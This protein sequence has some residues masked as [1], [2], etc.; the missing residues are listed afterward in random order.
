[1]RVVHQGRPCRWQWQ[2]PLSPSDGRFN[3]KRKASG[4]AKENNNTLNAR[5]RAKREAELREEQQR[6]LGSGLD[7]ELTDEQAKE[8]VMNQV[9]TNTMVADFMAA[10]TTDNPISGYFSITGRLI[11]EEAT[12][13][14]SNT[15][16]RPVVQPIDGASDIRAGYKGLLTEANARL[17]VEYTPEPLYSSY[18]ILNINKIEY[19]AQKLQ[20][21][22]P[23]GV[24]LWRVCNAGGGQDTRAGVGK[25]Y[26]I[27]FTKLI[28]TPE[29][30]RLKVVE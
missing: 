17:L 25:L 26:K 15:N 7:P 3:K 29:A 19:W 21:H 28:D 2:C 8:I 16:R 13:F 12:A 6:V 4:K 27:F 10:S 14:L 22:L 20:D 1:M 5:K 30:L 24:K 18:N 9:Y 23:L 11:K